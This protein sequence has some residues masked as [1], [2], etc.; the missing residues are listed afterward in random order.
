MEGV[1][2]GEQE[3]KATA[4]YLT[5]ICLLAFDK[6]LIPSEPQFPHLSDNRA[7]LCYFRQL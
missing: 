4:L 3:T 2:S 7:E 6:S 5:L 1:L